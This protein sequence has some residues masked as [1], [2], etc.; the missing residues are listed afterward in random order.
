[1]GSQGFANS[2]ILTM[3]SQPA[4]TT[5]S[6]TFPLPNGALWWYTAAQQYD[7]EVMAYSVVGSQPS[8]SPPSAFLAMLESDLLIAIANGYPQLTLVIHGLANLFGDSIAE[9][10]ALGGGL[11]Q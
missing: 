2:Y 1:M 8:A 10:A 11:Q 7:P 4:A 5:K 3:R 6:Q 9:L